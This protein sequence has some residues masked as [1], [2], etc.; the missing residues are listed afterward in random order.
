[1]GSSPALSASCLAGLTRVS[2]VDWPGRV[3]AVVFT[4][5]CNFRCP[6]CQNA[7]LVTGARGAGVTVDDVMAY[8]NKRSGVLDGL[9]ITGGEATLWPALKSFLIM[10][11]DIGLPVRLDTNGSHPRLVAELLRE[12]LVEHLAV[13]YKLPFEMYESVVKAPDAEAVR[14]TLTAGLQA[15]C[16]TARTTVVP[17]LHTQEMLQR[18]VDELPGLTLR[19]HR[20]Q[21]FRPG[22]CLDPAYNEREAGSVD[23]MKRLQS[24]LRYA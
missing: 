7:E 4:H 2:L 17:G 16:L 10:V 23:E 3:A 19:N 21:P 1:M 14:E 8:L 22:T 5:G 9:V 12:G 13:D 20:L 18:M 15:G 11:R 24:L 6:W